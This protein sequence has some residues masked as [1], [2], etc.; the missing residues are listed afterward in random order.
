MCVYFQHIKPGLC[1]LRMTLKV[2]P[3]VLRRFALAFS[4]IHISFSN[5]LD[6]RA[7]AEF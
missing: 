2:Q 1:Q 5:N 3:G 7:Y 4:L 6:H